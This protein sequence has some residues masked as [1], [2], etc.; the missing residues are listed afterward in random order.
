MNYLSVE[1]LTKSYGEKLLFEDISFGIDA[2]SK[3]ALIARN[4]TGKT[5]LLNIITGSDIPDSGKVVLR[6]D[7]RMAY[8]SQQP[9]FDESLS[10]FD[11][12]LSSETKYV[13][14]VRNYETAVAAADA[15]GAAD[16]L[17]KAI[18]E[19]DAVGAW[20]FEY[21]VKEVLGKLKITDTAAAV[22]TLSGGQKRKVA[23]AKVL[24]DDI[25]FL[26]MDEPTNHLDIE[27]IEWM[28]AF[29]HKQNLTIF[30]VTHDRYFLD[31]LCDE[32]LEIDNQKIYR[33]K[34]KYE[35][36]LTK[37]AERENAEK[38]EVM[39]A[40]NLY[41]RE[42]DWIRRMP[43][44]RTHKS[45]ARIDAFGDLSEK[46][47]RR[48]EEERPEIKVKSRRIGKKIL[49]INNLHMSFGDKVLIKDFSH[50]FKRGERIGVVGPNGSGKSTFFK[51]IM[52][53]LK[54]VAGRVVAGQT[55]VFGYFSQNILTP[56]TDKK[57]I[58]MVREVAE[59]IPVGE[60]STLS[61]S[62]FLT[63]F[64]F[65]HNTQYNYY[66]NL[67]GGEK[68]R[69]QLLLSLVNNPNF[70]IFDEPT[71]DLDIATLN[72]L[73]DFL[74]NYQGCLL[75]ATHDRAFIDKIVDHI[76][77]FED[78]GKIKDYHASYSEY[79]LM[80]EEKRRQ[81]ERQKQ[82][83]SGEKKKPVSRAK[84]PSYKQLKELEELETRMEK[85]EEKKAEL[86]RILEGDAEGMTPEDITATAEE[87][88]RVE[89]EL[90]SVTERW[91]ELE[92]EIESLKNQ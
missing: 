84:K 79:R 75:I 66:R 64:G 6:K 19:M 16:A 41:K 67:S 22:G 77:V 10:V 86:T 81:Q 46:A 82:E 57:V 65:D 37:K 80:K 74:S 36:Y 3:V 50:T 71:N 25:D 59:E 47:K 11:A 26:I 24:L 14:A 72:V 9:Q 18:M 54:P 13:K 28:E 33:Y 17:Q 53:E 23:L 52:G 43:K 12:I 68:R 60:S 32:I 42:L 35:Y 61:A 5:T 88:G 2:G 90:E 73:E 49:E 1:N 85:L 70:L 27:M 48:L 92:D 83:T 91:I 4:G 21:K 38:Q 45:K 29:L 7:I 40:K 15:P 58:D 76:F 30:V 89:A 51:L 56:E 39:K 78:G 8:L 20:D 34:G 69:L 63:Y 44:A 31:N 55:V 87:Y 62:G